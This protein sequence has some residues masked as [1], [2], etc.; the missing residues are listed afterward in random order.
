M[1][2]CE[3]YAPAIGD[4]TPIPR[5]QVADA[6]ADP[7]VVLWVELTGPDEG[8]LAWLTETFRLHPL[9]AEDLRNQR[10]RPKLDQYDDY[11]FLALR[12]PRYDPAARE[13]A[14]D[15]LHLL[16]GDRYLL[17][18][19][20]APMPVLDTVRQRWR[21]THPRGATAPFLFYLVLDGVVDGYFPI[22]DQIGDEIDDL[23]AEVFSTARARTQQKILALR[24]VLLAM[25]KVLGPTRDALNELL[26]VVERSP[27]QAALRA[28]Y[29]DVFDHVLRLTDFIDTYREMLSVSL[30]AMQS[31]LANQLN[32]NMQRLTVGATVLATATVIT[33]FFGMNLQGLLINSP[34]PYGGHALLAVLAI[35]TVIEIWYFR[36]I[37]WL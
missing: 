4:I 37:G 17:A 23:D 12:A 5:T 27:K 22:V 3:R 34:W 26:T 33:G 19:H 7:D 30:E 13:L 8:E 11:L 9:T 14:V 24:R 29:I 31:T 35:I 36:R 16:L 20:Q 6:L 18:V 15:E 21:Q 2:H 25:R 10:Q 28:Y 1:L 32:K